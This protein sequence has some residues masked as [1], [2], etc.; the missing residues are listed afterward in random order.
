MRRA[1][2]MNV[3][4]FMYLTSIFTQ[5]FGAPRPDLPKE[6]LS[7]AALKVSRF[8]MRAWDPISKVSFENE[9][10][11]TGVS[12]CRRGSGGERPWW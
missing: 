2:D 7:P 5:R 12:W 10:L 6:K 9:P 4:A 1:V 3:T 8:V 11:I